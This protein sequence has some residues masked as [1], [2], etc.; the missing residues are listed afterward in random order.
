MTTQSR[1]TKTDST[2]RLPRPKELAIMT[3]R[4]F[5]RCL[6]AENAL[7]RAA[8]S[9]LTGISKPTISESTQRLLKQQ[10]IVETS[11]RTT[12]HQ[13]PGGVIYQINAARGFALG[14]A[15]DSES[16]TAQA[17]NLRGETIWEL[18]QPLPAD[19]S[20]KTLIKALQETIKNSENHTKIPLLAICFSIA[21]PINP[22]SGKVISLPESPFPLA[23]NMDVL[24]EIIPDWHG[25]IA[26]DND[27][28]LATFAEH[29]LGT[30]Q[31]QDNFLYVYLGV[32]VGAGVF[33][34]G[35]VQRGANGLAGEIGYLKDSPNHTILDLMKQ[36]FTLQKQAGTPLYLSHKILDAIANSIVS[37]AIIINPAAIVIGGAFADDAN[38]YPYIK[39]KIAS[40]LLYPIEIVPSHFSKTGPLIGASI[41]A[42]EEALVA[43][44]MLD[45]S[46]DLRKVGF[47]RTNG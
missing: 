2:S 12:G 8:V 11:Q 30:M 45:A 15:I 28:N 25:P 21:D 13:G 10:L 26:I 40:L 42:Y 37:S 44:G 4:Q 19:G 24:E 32:G 38:V 7:T 23:H 33:M 31:E 46:T 9:Q 36:E 17:V 47:T 34:S 1:H 43:L 27:V 35:Q 20:R 3:D 6:Q 18:A 14:I 22:N 39:Q 16:L 5:F 41:T 29:K